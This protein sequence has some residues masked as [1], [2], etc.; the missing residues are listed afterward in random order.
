MISSRGKALSPELKKI[1]VSV[2]QYFDRMELTPT[3]PSV[4]LTADAIG[5]GIAT[6][7]I[8]ISIQINIVKN[9]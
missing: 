7:L 6:V 8:S 3:E 2:K 1:T 4:K 9:I 5:I